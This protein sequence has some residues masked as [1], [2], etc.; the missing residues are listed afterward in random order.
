MRPSTKDNRSKATRPRRKYLKPKAKSG[1]GKVEC[2]LQRVRGGRKLTMISHG[3]EISIARGVRNM[4]RAQLSGVFLFI[5]F[6]F[7][8]LSCLRPRGTKMHAALAMAKKISPIYPPRHQRKNHQPKSLW[9]GA[10]YTPA[11]S[12]KKSNSDYLTGAK[13]GNQIKTW[14][15]INRKTLAVDTN[16]RDALL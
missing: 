11:T 13:K 8:N 15:E 9:Y 5:Y 16:K 2:S 4:V 12:N 3:V 6:C 1:R 10:N 14:G 7:I